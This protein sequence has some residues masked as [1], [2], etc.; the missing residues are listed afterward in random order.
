MQRLANW[1]FG[2]LPAVGFGASVLAVMDR[3]AFSAWV[4]A[5]VTATGLIVQGV[6]SWYRQARDLK[7]SED[8]ADSS[9]ALES[10]QLLGRVQMELEARLAK[11]ELDITELAG[12]VESVRCVFPDPDG[13]PRCRGREIPPA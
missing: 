11:G 13:S 3:N 4:A 1:C 5:G 6:L 2:S 8:A 12:R 10:I 9:R 7:R